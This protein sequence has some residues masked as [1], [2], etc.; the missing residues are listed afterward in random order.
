VPAQDYEFVYLMAGKSERFTKVGFQL[1]KAFLNAA[2]TPLLERT[3]ETFGLTSCT[4][5][6]NAEQLKFKGIIEQICENSGVQLNL[7]VISPH[8]QGPSY[9]LFLASTELQSDSPMLIAYCD[10]GFKLDLLKFNTSQKYC[11]GMFLTFSGF[12]PHVIRNPRFGYVTVSELGDV[13][14]VHEKFSGTLTPEMQGSG[15]VY[16]FSSGNLMLRAIENQIENGKSTGGE[17]YISEAFEYLIENNLKVSTFKADKFYSWGTPEDLSDYNY[18]SNLNSKVNLGENSTSGH[19]DDSALLL[20]AGKSSRLN[21]DGQSPKQGI[22]IG[23]K[24]L[25]EYSLDL[26]SKRIR[27]I[28][29]LGPSLFGKVADFESKQISVILTKHQTRNSLESALC[30]FPKLFENSKTLHVLAS[31]NI[32]VIPNPEQ[33]PY[34]ADLLVWTCEKYP[35]TNYKKDAFSWVM[36]SDSNHV[37]KLSIKNLPQD[38][39]SWYPLTGNFSFKDS[40]TATRLITETLKCNQHEIEIHFEKIIDTALKLNYSIMIMDLDAY[41]TVGTPEE[42]ELAK[43]WLT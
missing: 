30:A 31:D 35:M 37:E 11:D 39:A 3:I 13:K 18:F 15:G 9:S 42:L 7:V 14:Q 1:P 23:S 41:M 32:C 16:Y 34:M 36:V 26:V 10:V 20:A 29:V 6:I 12:Q 17:F 28:A 2:G 5:V 27:T 38:G 40:Q 4:V 22:M 33:F 24:E 8:T 21:K 19:S 25:W 43:F